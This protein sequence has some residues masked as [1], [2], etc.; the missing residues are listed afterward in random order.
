MQCFS[1]RYVKGVPFSMEGILKG[2]LFCQKMEW[3]QVKT[4]Q[5]M[6]RAMCL[7]NCIDVHV[8]WIVKNWKMFAVTRKRVL[9]VSTPLVVLVLKF[10]NHAEET[11][12]ATT[13]TTL[14]ERKS[15][16]TSPRS[17]KARSGNVAKTKWEERGK[18]GCSLWLI[19]MNRL[20]GGKWTDEE[21]VIFL[22]H[23]QQFVWL[24]DWH[25]RELSLSLV[26]GWPRWR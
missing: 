3:K 11:V 10:R 25:H 4:N 1:C 12:S 14:T 24:L 22:Q 9:A 15:S 20:V 26:L 16:L 18:E 21:N 5:V 8:G 17:I 2:C 23:V 7:W 13:T 6:K 19:R